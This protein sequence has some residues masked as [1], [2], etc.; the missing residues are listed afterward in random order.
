MT[1]RHALNRL[2]VG[3]VFAA[4]VLAL[5]AIWLIATPA[6]AQAGLP[7]ATD[8]DRLL[9]PLS[10]NREGT[11]VVFRPTAADALRICV[12]QRPGVFGRRVCFTAGDVRRGL[13]V[14]R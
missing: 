7:L 2:L 9:S 10:I 1:S 12:E 3:L 5:L 14:R 11:E 8:A 4:V 6:H 13:V